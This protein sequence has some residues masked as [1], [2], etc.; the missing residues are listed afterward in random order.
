[1]NQ[2]LKF[3]NYK[4]LMGKIEKNYSI[5]CETLSKST[6]I[7][8]SVLQ[9]F[10][11]TGQLKDI[12]DDDKHNLF[13]LL[14]LLDNIPESNEDQRVCSVIQVLHN[15]YGISLQ[16]IALYAQLDLNQVQTFIND[17]TSIKLEEKYKLAVSSLFLYFVL[18][19]RKDI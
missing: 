4:G 13:S 9:S 19:K 14:L 16:T 1:M 8:Q 5:S 7:T 12:P 17:Q 15:F 6:G 11:T 10:Q 2:V 3:G 18:S